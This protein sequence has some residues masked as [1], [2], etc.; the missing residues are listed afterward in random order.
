MVKGIENPLDILWKQ[1]QN[2][3]QMP[4]ELSQEAKLKKR[5]KQSPRL[6]GWL[7]MNLKI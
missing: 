4:Y 2:E 6:S 7:F 5:K 3:M 1:E